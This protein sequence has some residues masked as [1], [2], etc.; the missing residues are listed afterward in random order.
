MN[1][2]KVYLVDF[3]R[4]AF[5]RSRPNDPERDVFNSIRMDEAMAKLINVV[6]DETGIKPEEIN[7]VITGCALQMDENW[8]YGGRHPILLAN[9]PEN[10]P[11]MALDRAC[12][13]SLNAITIG[14]MEIMTG[15]SDIVMAGGYEHMTHVPMGN[16]PFLKP[17]IKLMVRPEYMHWDMN[18]G[19]SM[20]LTAEKL[21][22]LRGITRD[23]MDRYSLRSH[24]L[25]SKALD[26]GYFK[27]EIVPVEVEINGEEKVIDTDQSIRKN[28]SLEDMK[29]LKPAFKDDGVITAGNSSPLNAGA[30]LTLLMSEKKVKEYGLKPMARI[31]SFGWAG[32]DPSIMGEGP[33]P[34]TKNALAKAKMDVSDIDL[35]EINEAFAVVVLNAMKELG[36]E[37]DRVNVHGGAIA[38]GHP[39]GATGARIAGTLARIMNE[40]KKDYGVATLCVGGGQGYSVVFERY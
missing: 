23:E 16:S 1:S 9:L 29:K 33:V 10:V 37:E 31:V 26:D 12:S 39:L 32:V 36:I 34:A 30:S 25:A 17:N 8:T 13:S 27:G 14:A 19:Y 28:T 40:K 5:S 7:D 21:A 6:I 38:I 35:W 22:A 18:T 20:G 11:G 15:N 4:T 2:E 24:Q 3:K